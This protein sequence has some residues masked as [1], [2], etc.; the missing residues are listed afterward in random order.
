METIF[1]LIWCLFLPFLLF[2][3][4][5]RLFFRFQTYSAAILKEFCTLKKKHSPLAFLQP[6]IFHI[7]R[8]LT[9]LNSPLEEYLGPPATIKQ[10]LNYPQA[11][12]QNFTKIVRPVL[13]Q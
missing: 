4:P 13:P 11:L 5:F 6:Q 9:P 12:V 8:F 2:S 7:I 1:F 3:A 10:F